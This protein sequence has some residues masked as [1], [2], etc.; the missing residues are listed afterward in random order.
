LNRKN[1]LFAFVGSSHKFEE[2]ISVLS[3]SD[4]EDSL[5][6]VVTWSLGNFVL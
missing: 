2:E 6:N 1:Y 4:G 3:V 5:A